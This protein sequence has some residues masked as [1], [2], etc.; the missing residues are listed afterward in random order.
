MFVNKVFVGVVVR[1]LHTRF[2]IVGYFLSNVALSKMTAKNFFEILFLIK[3]SE[4]SEMSYTL[5][6]EQKT[7]LDNK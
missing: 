4:K 2:R 7:V 3:L 6:H 1:I 5:L